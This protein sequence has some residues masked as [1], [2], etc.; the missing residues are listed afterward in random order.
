MKEVETIKFSLGKGV[1]T[2]AQLTGKFRYFE[3]HSIRAWKVN[4]P[5]FAV[6]K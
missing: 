5:K 2:P 3:V 4:A 1:Y 6:D